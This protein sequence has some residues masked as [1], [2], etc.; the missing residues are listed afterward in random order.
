MVIDPSE[1]ERVC[2]GGLLPHPAAGQALLPNKA[3]TW[4]PKPLGDGLYESPFGGFMA[5]AGN[6]P[7]GYYTASALKSPGNVV[8]KHY[9]YGPGG[10]R[11]EYD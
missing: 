5:K 11:M 9:L 6:L 4:P 1:L 7:N 3:P 10:L 8:L 2:G